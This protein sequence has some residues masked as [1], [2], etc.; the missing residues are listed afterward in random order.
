ML[1]FLSSFTPIYKVGAAAAAAASLI[2]LILSYSS[3]TL[4]SLSFAPFFFAALSFPGGGRLSPDI[5]AL[6][7]FSRIFRHCNNPALPFCQVCW[8]L[9][10]C[11]EAA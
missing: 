10:S 6:K 7:H 8:F 2:F 4:P 5:L 11:L 3:F 9:T 1:Y